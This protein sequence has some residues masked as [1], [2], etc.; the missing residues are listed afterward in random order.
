MRTEGAKEPDVYT[1][2]RENRLLTLGQTREEKVTVS[3][4]V[5]QT[6]GVTLSPA[7]AAA[8]TEAAFS[9][10]RNYAY[11]YDYR[12]RRVGRTEAGKSSAVVFLGGLS[13]LEYGREAN[14]ARKAQPEVEHIRG[15][16]MAGGV[17][18]MVYSVRGGDPSYN[19]YDSRGDV[20]AKANAAGAFTWQ[21]SYEA[22]GTRTGEQGANLERQRANTKDED[23]TGLLNEGMR[24]RDLETGVWLTRDPAGFVDGP[25]LYAYVRQNPWTSFDPLGLR[26]AS[27]S[28]NAMLKKLLGEAGIVRSAAQNALEKYRREN[29]DSAP[30]AVPDNIRR[31]LD[32]A[33]AM[34][35]SARRIAREIERV[36]PAQGT[37]PA[38]TIQQGFVS[39]SKPWTS[40]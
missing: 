35:K 5:I 38:P 2:D 24:Y 36:L 6:G 40:G 32:S 9:R 23:P 12:T 25:N 8:R 7:A 13:V 11:T 4:S 20:V 14:G 27:D 19:L 39:P 21:A 34:G 31:S 1:Y 29:P 17:G 3:V 18:G 15:S 10:R 30:G 16:G 37:I 26:E 28:E 22:Y 33:A